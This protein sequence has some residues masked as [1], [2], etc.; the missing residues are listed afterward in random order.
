MNINVELVARAMNKAGQ[1]PLTEEELKTKDGTR[2][3]VIKD[4]YLSVILESLSATEWTSQKKRAK[5]ELSKDES[6]SHYR[7]MY[8][9]P[10]DCAKAVSLVSEKEYVIENGRLY[11]NDLNAALIYVSNGFTGK[12]KFKKADP[13]PSE[14]NFSEKEYYIQDMDDGYTKADIYLPDT[15]YFVIDEE[16]YNFY[17]DPKLDPQLSAYVETKLAA[18]IVLKLTGN[19]QLYQMLY[20]EAMIMENKAI[21]AS[22]E[23]GHS[24]AKGDKWWGEVIGMPGY[25][26]ED[27]YVNY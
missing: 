27:D 25:E 11:T 24:R 13:V 14:L 26:S 12:Y 10:K 18:N 4:F 9:L 7:C 3:R 21:K 19:M 2:W 8:E 23:A 17:D 1:E 5:L 15:T 20:N 16:D 22:R 6:L